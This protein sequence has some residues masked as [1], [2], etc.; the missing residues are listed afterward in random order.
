MIDR[1]TSFHSF[2]VPPYLSA[3]IW[4]VILDDRWSKIRVFEDSVMEGIRERTRSCE[5]LNMDGVVL[6]DGMVTGR[7]QSWLSSR[8]VMSY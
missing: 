8:A 5:R 6:S 4:D 2:L 1:E 3:F 7:L